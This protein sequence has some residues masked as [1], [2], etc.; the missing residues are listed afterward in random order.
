VNLFNIFFKI[1]EKKKVLV[2]FL[3]FLFFHYANANSSDNDS[4]YIEKGKS[5]VL[6]DSLKNHSPRLA[7]IM[8]ATLPGLGQ[9]YNKKIWKAPVIYTGFGVLGYIAFDLNKKY[10]FYK[11][12]YNDAKNPDENKDYSPSQLKEGRDYYRKYRDLTFIGMGAWYILNIIDANVDAHFYYYDI[13]DDLTIN[14]K[15]ILEIYS[16]SQ[17]IGLSVMLKF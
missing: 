9:I 5:I 1:S 6:E 12:L 8:S 16:A 17:S 2:F 10:T 14:F 4:L 15:P 13:S 3:Y 11:D 7:T